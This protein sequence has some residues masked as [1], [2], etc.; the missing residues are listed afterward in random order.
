MTASAYEHLLV[1]RNAGVATGTLNRTDAMNA[2]DMGVKGKLEQVVAHELAD[3]VDVR[4]V[5]FTGAGRPFLR[6]GR[7]R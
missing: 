4:C 1:A 5:G 2:F 6:R 3:D 7:N